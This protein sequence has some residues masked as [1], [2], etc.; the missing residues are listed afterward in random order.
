MIIFFLFLSV[1]FFLCKFSDSLTWPT[2]FVMNLYLK[3]ESNM[4][5]HKILLIDDCKESQIVVCNSLKKKFQIYVASNF[6]EAMTELKKGS[7]SL[8]ILDVELPEMDGFKIC[9]QIKLMEQHR[10]TSLIFLS[11]RQHT[12]DKV[13]GLSLGADDFIV[14]PFDHVEFVA[15]VEVRIRNVEEHSIIQNNFCVGNFRI[16]PSQNKVFLIK[17]TIETPIFFTS[18]EFKLLCYLLQHESQIL[19]RQKLLDEVWGQLA[20]VTDRTIDTHIYSIRKKLGEFA[21]HIQSVPRIGYRYSQK[22]K[23]EAA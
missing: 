14:K 4:S 11:G 8:I 3:K 16:V 12:S 20:N 15:R 23:L 17:D 7:F 10:R 22:E 9:A 18:M 2:T 19:S 5:P 13:M 6:D 1:N 21:D